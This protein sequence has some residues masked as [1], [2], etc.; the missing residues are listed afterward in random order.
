VQTEGANA[1]ETALVEGMPL[2]EF[3]I[4]E[5]SAK[6]D[7]N[8]VDGRARLAELARPLLGR[9]P[10]GVYRELLTGE[11]AETVGLSAARLDAILSHKSS[12][13]AAGGKTKA[14]PSMSGARRIAAGNPSVV[15]RAI[16]LLLHHPSAANELDVERL[17]GVSRP[18]VELLRDLI[19]MLQAEPTLTTA[20]LLE[21]WRNHDEGRHLGKLAAVELPELEEFD[22]VSELAA[23]MHQLAQAGARDR[24]QFLI[25][26]ERLGSLSDAE[27]SELRS[28]GRGAAA[29]G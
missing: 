12:N 7:L 13:Q 29:S 27:R 26:K 28:L 16:T 23:C 24:I 19:E 22:P 5:L 11:L 2:S 17:A 15:R 9:I 8:S 4:G 1:F 6:V 18:G 14:T 25:E 10:A 21:R 20:G 3:L